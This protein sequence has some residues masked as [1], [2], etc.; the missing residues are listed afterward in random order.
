MRSKEIFVPAVVTNVHTIDPGEIRKI[1][2][3]LPSNYEVKG[4]LYPI[5]DRVR[6]GNAFLTKP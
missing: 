4:E 1:E 3:T 5:R 6:P 2:L